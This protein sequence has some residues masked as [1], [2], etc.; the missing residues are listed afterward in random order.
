M[1][2]FRVD[3]GFYDHPKVVDLSMAARGLWAT[4]GSY[5]GR[6]LTD[7]HISRKQVRMLGGTAAQIRDLIRNRMWI[8]CESHRDCIAFVNWIEQQPTR[9]SVETKRAE[10]A[11]RKHKAR[12][13]KRAKQQQQENVRTDVRSDRDESVRADVQQESALPDPTRPDPTH[14]TTYVESASHEANASDSGE[15]GAG[16]P[17]HRDAV[18]L[19]RDRV[20]AEHPSAVRTML[21]LR[22]SE[23]I[24]A[25]TDPGVV[26]EALDR[27]V[28][29]SGIGPNMLPSL[30][31]DVIKE[32]SGTTARAA[33]GPRRSTADDRVAAAQAL[34]HRPPGANP[35]PLLDNATR[36]AIE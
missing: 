2:W 10:D 7:G 11:E 9:D 27:W 36:R 16:P 31:S 25:G 22:A 5:C 19:V 26:A 3:D 24:T 35:T 32:R 1:T 18:R 33:P 20:P 29:K 15:R 28:G 12:E 13:A 34:K 23:L 8:E 14:L 30:V 17:I 4:C 6:H 21:R